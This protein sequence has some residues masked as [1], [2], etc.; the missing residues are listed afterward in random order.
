MFS[1]KLSNGVSVVAE[2][3]QGYRSASVGV[4]FG[5][6]SI[7][8]D[9]ANNG[10]SHFIEHMLFKG[11]KTRTAGE[12]AAQMD[13]LGGNLNAFTAKECT[14]YYVKVLGEF[15]E[16]ALD[17]LADI[18]HNSRFDDKDIQLEKGV[19]TDEILMTED[20]PEDVAHD[21]ISA[22]VFAGSPVARP[23]I[24]T[25]ET[26]KSFTRD[27]LL[28]YMNANYSALNTV[29]SCAG[30]FER[31]KLM[32]MLEERFGGSQAK[33]LRPMPKSVLTMR[34]EVKIVDKDVEQVHIC[35]GMPGYKADDKRQYALLVLNNAL[36]GS[37]S[38]RLFQKIREERGLAY[39]VYTYP[40]AY[41]ETGCFT[42]YAGTG[43]KQA[44][45]VLGLIKRELDEI[46]KNGI[47]DEEFKRNKD[48]LI[49]SFMLGQESTG[50]RSNA[51]GK[52]QLMRG[53]V[54][55]EDEILSFLRAVTMDD[56]RE[57]TKEVIDFSAMSASLVGRLNKH[58]LGE[59]LKE[60]FLSF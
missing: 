35:L 22:L 26:V 31:D 48:Q 27:G 25:K 55:S 15:L 20:S 12:I 58:K 21:A 45:E 11:T 51:I 38:S 52:A 42:V 36:G 1:Q 18:V 29:I 24:G 19:V 44:G 4:W 9:D 17:I 46:A 5:A 57:I 50:A 32:A 8:E 43:E 3:M 56:V 28:N 40:T 2:K 16:P 14:C 59:K 33:P 39:S 34:R 23:I 37:M 30:A 7:Y 49:A 6:G 10:S 60:S 53:R 41:K 47:T 13:A 54:Y